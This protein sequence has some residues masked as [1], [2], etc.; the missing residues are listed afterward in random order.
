MGEKKWQILNKSR[1]NKSQIKNEDIIQILLENRGLNIKREIENFLHPSEPYTLTARDTKIDAAALRKALSRIIKAIKNKESIVVYADYDA[2]GVTAGAIMWETLHKLGANVMPYV[3][4]RVDEGYGLSVKGID[5]VRA[6]YDPQL[7]ITVDHGITAWE[8]VDY[9]K[10]LGIEV[11]VTDHHVKPKKVPKCIIVHTTQLSGAGVAWFVAKELLNRRR[12][13]ILGSEA[14]PKSDSQKRT[15]SA[16]A[17]MTKQRFDENQKRELLALA[18]IGTIADMVPLIGANRAI[19]KY[20]LEAINTTEKV[21]LKALIKDAGLTQ[22]DIR[23]YQISHMLAPRLNAMGRLEHAM[24]ALRLLCTRKEDKAKMLAETLGLTNRERQQLTEETTLHALQGLTL[25]RQGET[26]KKLIFVAHR[27]YNQGVIGLVAG[28]LVDT[29]YRP[30]IVVARGETVSKA[31]ARSVNGFNIIEAIRSCMDIL[32][33]AGGHPMAAGFT[34]ETAKLEELQSRLE[35]LTEK[36]L[37]EEQ[38]TRVLKI[39]AEISL[40]VVS[41]ELWRRIQEFAPYG[42]GNPEPVF[43]TRNIQVVDARLVGKDGKHLKLRLRT[44]FVPQG[45]QNSELRN[46]IFEAIGFG[47]GKLYKQLSPEKPIEVAYTIDLDTWNGNKRLQLKLKDLRLPE[48]KM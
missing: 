25:Q 21:G 33:D 23:T 27:N 32:V 35:E 9:A 1:N 42:M 13:V 5:N 3:P 10:K 36:E 22:G 7:I 29:Y 4:H 47:L 40:A 14:A 26:F 2:D 28:K 17:R 16:Q 15:D 18:A 41:E 48:P 11:I 30:A 12:S 46:E 8:K 44:R 34:V 37:D 6:R 31:S 24:D 43:A 39:D 45:K 38:L 20:G 19:A